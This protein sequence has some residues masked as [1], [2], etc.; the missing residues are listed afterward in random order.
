MPQYPKNRW[1]GIALLLYL[2]AANQYGVRKN[3]F[4]RHRSNSVCEVEF[5]GKR[6]VSHFMYR[7]NNTVP[8]DSHHFIFM[9]IAFIH[10]YCY[11]SGWQMADGKPV[12]HY[13]NTNLHPLLISKY[14]VK[15]TTVP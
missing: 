9:L 12:L 15:A 7:S 13:T 1:S 4:S 3:A 11:H 6:D 5:L 14:P 10:V 8:F 2:L